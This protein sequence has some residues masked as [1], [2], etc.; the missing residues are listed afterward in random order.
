M[1][2][3]ISYPFYLMHSS[4][5]VVG[6]VK[7]KENTSEILDHNLQQYFPELLKFESTR[8]MEASEL[9]QKIKPEVERILNGVV[10]SESVQSAG[11]G[12]PIRDKSRILNYV[13][14]LA[15]NIERGTRFDGIVNALNDHDGLRDRDVLLLTE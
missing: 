9:Y 2:S 1:Y 14:T 12:P 5:S 6:R 7:G 15:W 3:T 13:S 11:F 10:V 8:E 4:T